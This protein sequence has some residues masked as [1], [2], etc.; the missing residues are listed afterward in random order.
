[1]NSSELER[2]IKR[3]EFDMRVV[4]WL[5]GTSILVLILLTV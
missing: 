4:T 5:Y 1:M 2:R 3:L